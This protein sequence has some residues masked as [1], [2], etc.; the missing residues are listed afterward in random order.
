VALRRQHGVGLDRT[1]SA[2]MQKTL[3]AWGSVVEALRLCGIVLGAKEREA[4][5]GKCLA[6]KAGRG[7]SRRR[8]EQEAAMGY[9]LRAAGQG[10]KLWCSC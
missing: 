3:T 7:D 6:G 10:S 4:L 5:T 8:L 2:N 9:G 1:R